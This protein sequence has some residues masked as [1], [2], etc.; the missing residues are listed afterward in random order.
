MRLTMKEE[1]MLPVQVGCECQSEHFGCEVTASL[2][3]MVT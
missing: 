1:Y 2:T 3:D